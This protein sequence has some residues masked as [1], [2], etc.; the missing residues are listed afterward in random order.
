MSSSGIKK[1]ETSRGKAARRIKTRQKSSATTR[2]EKLSGNRTPVTKTSDNYSSLDLFNSVLEA[3]YIQDKNGVFLD[4]NKGAEAMYGYPRAFFIGKT[5]E[6]ISAPG[7]NDL[8]AVAAAVRKA[9]RGKPQQFEYWGRRRNGEIFPKDVRLYPG[10]HQGKKVVIA[11]ALDI[12]EKKQTD[13]ILKIF[14]SSVEHSSDAVG[15]S[16]PEGRHFYQ[17]KAF[18]DLFGAIGEDPPATLY[19]NETQGREVFKTIQSGEIWNGEVLMYSKEKKVLSIFLRAYPLKDPSGH[20]TALVGI[21]TDITERKRSEAILKESEERYRLLFESANDAI[22]LMKDDR[23]ID[24]NR[25]TL[26]MFRCTREQIIGQPPYRFSPD[27]QPDGSPSREKALKKIHAAFEGHSQ[28]FEW[29][30]LRYDGT[31]FDA[32][33]SL[34]RIIAGNRMMLQAIVRDITE[35]KRAEEAL[36][37]SEER[38]NIAVDGSNAGMWD[39]DMINDHVVFSPYWKKMLG[40]DDHEVENS[41]AGW[42]NLWHPE[43]ET[44][45]RKAVD[46]HLKGLTANYEIIH[47]LRHKNGEWRWIITR[48]KLL[49]DANGRPYRW[50]GTNIDITEQKSAELALAASQRKYKQ[51]QELFRNMADNLP[52]MIWA[53]DIQKNYIFVN[54]SICTNLLNAKDTEEPIGKSDMF[55]AERERAAHPENPQ[56]HTFGEICRDSDAVVLKSGQTGRFDEYGNVKGQFLYLDVIKTPLRNEKGEIIGLVGAARDV[57]D[58]K[59][60]EEAL[61][62]SEERF[63]K[64]FEHSPMPILLVRQ[65]KILYVNE[66]FK[67]TLGAEATDTFAGLNILDFIERADQQRITSYIQNRALNLPAPEHYECRGIRKDGT[68]VL[69]AVHIA[70]LDLSDGPATMAFCRDITETKM[71]EEALRSSEERFRK[72]FESSPI[73]ILLARQGL[74]LYTNEAFI[75]GVGA[76]SRD[77]VI[78]ASVMDFIAHE[79][80]DRIASYIRDRAAGLSVPEHYECRGLRQDG[81][82][83]LYEINI[84]TVELSDGPATMAFY[85]DITEQRDMENQIRQRETILEAMAFAADRFLTSSDWEIHMDAILAKLGQAVD[86]SRTYIFEVHNG[87]GDEIFASQRF[88]W[89]APGIQAQMLN[90]ELQHIP[91]RASGYG[92]WVDLLQAGEMISGNIGE[93]PESEQELLRA[94][95]VQSI[96]IAPIFIE[97]QWWGFIGYDYCL[98][99]RSWPATQLDLLKAT[100]SLFAKAIEIRRAEEKLRESEKRYKTLIETSQDA[101]SLLKT[102]G[103]ILF[104]NERK[105]QMVGASGPNEL[106]GKNAFDFLTESGRM[107][108]FSL[109]ERFLAAGSM[110]N[111]EAEVLRLD[112][113]AFTAELN[114][115]VLYDNQG[116]PEHI[117]YTMRDISR[118]KQAEEALRA[119]RADLQRHL[120]FTESLLSAIPTPVFFKDTHGKYIGCNQAFTELMGVRPEDIIGKTV[121]ECWP[122]DLAETY[123]QKDMELLQHP[124]HQKYDFRIK[125]KDGI[126][127]DVIFIKDVFYDDQKKVAGLVGA[128]LDISERKQAEKALQE[129]EEKY[130]QLIE[131]SSDAIYLLYNRHFEIINRRFSELFEISAEEVNDPSFDFIQLVAPKSRAVIEERVLR[132]A[133]GETLSPNYSFTART[134]SGREI[135]IE[136]SVSYIEYKNGVAVQGILRDITERNRLEA[137]LRQAQKME[138]V[139]QLAAGVAHDFNNIL[140]VISGYTSLMLKDRHLDR[141]VADKISEIQK[142]GERAQFLTNQLLAFSRKQIINPKLIDINR[143]IQDSLKMLTRLIGEDIYIQLRLREPVP[144]ILADPIQLEQ[145]LINLIVNARDAIHENKKPDAQK[146]ITIETA[147][148]TVEADSRLLSAE[149]GDRRRLQLTIIDTGIGMD[150]TVLSRIFDPFFTTKET[151][152]GTGLGLSTV[153][154]IIKQNNASIEADSEPGIGTTFRILWPLAG[155]DIG[156]D[157]SPVI[158][159]EPLKGSETILV[160]EDNDAV[161]ELTTRM[162]ENLGY[163]VL[164]AASG[165]AAI[166]LFVS[167]GEKVDLLLTDLVMPGISGRELADQLHII[168]ADL[169]VIFT[170]GYTDDQII[171]RGVMKDQVIY[172][173][174][175]FD[176]QQLSETIHRTLHPKL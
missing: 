48:G 159:T 153:Y 19:V 152:R 56:W 27:T 167:S 142:A 129:S 84:A 169:P 82:R 162:L 175:P 127:H 165:E 147:E 26:E 16:T 43:D 79:D 114:G 144:L 90:P 170:S 104:C 113:S 39:W 106:I 66:A 145:I 89:C 68:T 58:R 137:Q 105:A 109:M 107:N 138:A 116:R 87:D 80:R 15:M 102:D 91:L 57:T 101:I 28:F 17:N 81:K 118:R 38:L 74:I 34:N 4:V 173:Q 49:K 111:V 130:R 63:R 139:G 67:K 119:S 30:H 117:M 78:G 12:T 132:A 151:G 123:H 154:G 59:L 148:T 46:D 41:F 71:A 110:N 69:L 93:L 150:A 9:Y 23:F 163:R 51:L 21:H 76:D 73:P 92:R 77:S 45:I 136:A 70:M 32:E 10:Y 174:K 7:K 55:F 14:K 143:L 149:A 42:R 96:V 61:R 164:A 36:R 112:G 171:H 156:K 103:T 120:A 88:E 40:Y 172:I 115:S 22:F 128:F 35:R 85:R 126:E 31:P 54:Q 11:L 95:D 52:D 47:R 158:D 121:H 29:R 98:S 166:E 1:K 133:R 25:R 3:I 6:F 100:A 160:V 146:I 60:A 37:I 122:S 125:D 44:K 161:R 86:V 62:A 20:V 13:K 64:L 140:T 75:K 94:Q 155:L 53:K 135:D 83:V 33:V 8:K 97:Q 24:C 141:T 2:K 134:R 131:Q 124:H 168:R 72:L 18:D 65:E 157:S 50:V 99:A 176:I 108:I 5:P